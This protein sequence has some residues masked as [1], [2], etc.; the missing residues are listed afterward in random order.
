VLGEIRLWRDGDEVRA[1]VE[2]R[3]DHVMIVP[4]LKKQTGK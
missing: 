2:T 1:E 3:A 4:L